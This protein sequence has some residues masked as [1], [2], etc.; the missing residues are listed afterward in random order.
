MIFTVLGYLV[1][2]L[3]AWLAWAGLTWAISAEQT[4]KGETMASEVKPASRSVACRG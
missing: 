3:L 1:L 2:L 4:T